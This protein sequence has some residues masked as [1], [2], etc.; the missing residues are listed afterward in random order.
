MRRRSWLPT[1]VT[2]D[3]VLVA[4][5]L[6][7]VLLVV[8]RPG[9]PGNPTLPGGTGTAGASVPAGA[10]PGP[11]PTPTPGPPRFRLPSD[12]I[13]CTM[14]AD[15]VTCTIVSATFTPP[16]VQGCTG[17]VGHTVV[18]DGTGVSVPCVAG[19]APTPAGSSVPMLFYGSTS[20]VGRYT[21][22]SATDGVTCTDPK[23]VGFRLAREAL[24]VLP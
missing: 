24:T 19:P 11:T 23:G 21:C 5:V 12:N 9:G 7:L 10:A 1:L 8:V 16:P 14:T 17:S 18:L 22:T 3:A 4:A 6:V 15:S 2:L 13:A 20:T